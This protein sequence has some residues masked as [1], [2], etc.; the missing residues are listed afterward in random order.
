VGKSQYREDIAERHIAAL[1]ATLPPDVVAAAQERGWAR[2]LWTTV[3]ELLAELG[4]E[5]VL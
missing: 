1:S 4:E 5:Q 2:D 3:E